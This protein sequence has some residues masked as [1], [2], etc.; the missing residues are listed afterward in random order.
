MENSPSRYDKLPVKREFITIVIP[1]KS[2][3]ANLLF[4]SGFVTATSEGKCECITKAL[5]LLE[6]I[7]IEE[8]QLDTKNVPN[9]LKVNKSAISQCKKML[10]CPTCTTMSYF[11]ALMIMIFHKVMLSYEQMLVILTAQF[12]KLNPENPYIPSD[13]WRQKHRETLNRTRVIGNSLQGGHDFLVI[14]EYNLDVEEEP[15][16]F[17]GLVTMQLQT[18]LKV[19]ARL[20]VT[21]RQSD[22][23]S[24]VAMVRPIEELGWEQL[25][26][27]GHCTERTEDKDMTL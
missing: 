22:L 3:V 7:A 15:C 20:K 14:R 25:R 6:E 27:C 23:S 18:L 16:V 12:N 13:E 11:I 1:W 10:E 8:I 26:I 24:H 19:L 4:S 21:L 5:L 9:W 17:G 2:H